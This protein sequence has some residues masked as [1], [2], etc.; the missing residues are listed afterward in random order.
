MKKII[1]V[2]MT[3]FSFILLT[4]C[5]DNTRE[6]GDTFEFD[7][8]E[9]TLSEDIGF[10]RLR[11]RWSDHD[12]SYVFYI[13]ITVTN[14]GDGSHGLN[15]WSYTVY[16]PDGMS[17]DSLGWYFE[18]TN[19]SSVGNIQPDTT[20]DGHIY[21]LYAEDG[22]YI[23]EFD[24]FDTTIEV[25]F[26]LE[27]DFAAVPE[28]QT[29]FT[30]GETL[31]IEGLEITIADNIS[32]GL[33]RSRTDLNGEYYFFLPVTL[34]NLSEETTGFPW[35]FDIFGPNGNALDSIAWEVEEDDISRGAGDIL[36]GA[37]LTGY[38]HVLFVGDGEY[39]FEFTDWE[40]DDSLRVSF[41]VEFDP[42]A[43][44][45]IQT[46]FTLDELF[47]FDNLE[48][49][50]SADGSWGTIE[51]RWSDLDGEDYFVLPVTATNIG[52]STNRFPSWNI[53]IFG[54]GGIELDDI[55]WDVDGD[56]ITRSG[57]IRAGATLEG[58]LHIL[59]DGY[60]EYVI[61]FSDWDDT[62][63]IIFDLEE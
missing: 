49:I 32:W 53:T 18:E 31:E 47:V 5:G 48:I 61:E 36:P 34:N 6:L 10:T 42:D 21:I 27:F 45:V 58:D 16:S 63:Q 7:D 12:G 46:E 51:S 19:I 39:I 38:L 17:I 14:I 26:E 8:L 56:D 29:E 44:P 54:P 40:F 20:K 35:G 1:L 22:E 52:N 24:N 60:G 62:I 15:E 28:I 30:L 57:D 37:T 23:I 2:T 13:P 4:A 9:I 55:S 41:N 50:I 3:I 33:I 11:R 59:F 25:H 43:V